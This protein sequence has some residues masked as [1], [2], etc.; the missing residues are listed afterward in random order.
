MDN[1]KNLVP[2]QNRSDDSDLSASGLPAKFRLPML[3]NVKGPLLARGV[4]IFGITY[5]LT[6]TFTRPVVQQH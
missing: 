4:D 6:E 5:G 3:E 1:G 2:P